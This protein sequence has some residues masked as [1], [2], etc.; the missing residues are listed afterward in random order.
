MAMEKKVAWGL[1]YFDQFTFVNGYP[2]EMH[3]N[4]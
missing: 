3:T 2:G 4:M 1:T